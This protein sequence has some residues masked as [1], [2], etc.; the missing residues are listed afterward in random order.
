MN[1]H[2]IRHTPR[3]H[4]AATES[5]VVRRHA[6]RSK[7]AEEWPRFDRMGAMF[8]RQLLASARIQPGHIVLDVGCGAGG[9][10]LA[11]ANELV[12]GGLALGIDRDA[13]AIEVARERVLDAS[14]DNTEFIRGDAARYA[15]APYLADSIVSRFGTMHFDDPVAA[16]SHLHNTLKPGGRLAFVSWRDARRNAWAT[17]PYRAISTV[18]QPS[19]S[20]E[21]RGPFAFADAERVRNVLTAAGFLDISLTSLDDPVCVGSSVEDAVE[22]VDAIELSKLELDARE[23]SRIH[24]AL[25][26]ALLPFAA[27]GSRDGANGVW[28]PASAWLVEARRA[29]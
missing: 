20:V 24:G 16:Y 1:Q 6:R 18:R 7:F 15:F 28:M 22:F 26:S 3:H 27:N 9:T 8:D 13:D 12:D 25:R 11:A 23:R 14:I 10:T 17:V 5:G 4:R 21:N 29:S 2:Q 19:A